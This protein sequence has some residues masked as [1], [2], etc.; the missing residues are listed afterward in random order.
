[1]HLALLKATSGH[2]P[3]HTKLSALV[4][5]SAVSPHDD[6][7]VSGNSRLILSRL[8]VHRK[9][10]HLFPHDSIKCTKNRAEGI[11]LMVKT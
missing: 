9:E 10:D 3:P 6:I 7:M 2:L 4:S 1:M 11:A 8:M 5:A